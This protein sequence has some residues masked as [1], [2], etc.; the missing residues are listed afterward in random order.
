M[1]GCPGNSGQIGDRAAQAGHVVEPLPGDTCQMLGGATAEVDALLG[2]HAHGVEVKGLGVA[3]GAE[4]L[5]F[6][7]GEMLD[8]RVG[9]LGAAVLPVQRRAPAR[10]RRLPQVCPDLRRNGAGSPVQRDGPPS[11]S[12]EVA[13]VD[14]SI[15]A[16]KM[17]RFMGCCDVHIS[18][19]EAAFLG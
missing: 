13:A 9:D 5:D 14:G 16:A 17:H 6:L 19:T 7:A 11:A 4:R 15:W 12:S 1:S 10:A 18:F 2:Q 8:Q 3:A